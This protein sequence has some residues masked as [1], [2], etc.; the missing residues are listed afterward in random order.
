MGS[1]CQ[2]DAKNEE[3]GGE[4]DSGSTSQL[5]DDEP[6]REHAENLADEV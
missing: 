2:Y 4:H 6:E 3:A 1:G 5:I